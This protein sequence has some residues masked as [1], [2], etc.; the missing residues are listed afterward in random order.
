MNVPRNPSKSSPCGGRRA[1]DSRRGCR[2]L[3]QRRGWEASLRPARFPNRSWASGVRCRSWE[4]RWGYRKL[5]DPVVFAPAA[6]AAEDVAGLGFGDDHVHG[7]VVRLRMDGRKP[8]ELEAYSD[9]QRPNRKARDRHVVITGTVSKPVARVIEADERNDQRRGEYRL[10]R[11]RMRNVPD[12][13]LHCRLFC[14]AAE[15][16]RLAPPDHDRQRGTP[17]ARKHFAHVR[18]AVEYAAERPIASDE[19]V[20]VRRKPLEQILLDF[21][22]RLLVHGERHF[23]AQFEQA[24]A[25]DAAPGAN[26]RSRFL[27]HPD[28]PRNVPHGCGWQSGDTGSLSYIARSAA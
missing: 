4:P 2:A 10:A 12:A 22:V 23:P 18:N 9:T 1:Q 5:S 6:L 21:F 27:T 8:R 7:L 14:P 11:G 13:T 26:L 20:A 17:A 24:R 19:F 3:P 16:E 15:F 28:C 25:F